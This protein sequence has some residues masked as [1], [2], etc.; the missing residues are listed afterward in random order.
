MSE[1]QCPY[2]GQSESKVVDSRKSNRITREI[3]CIYR[4]RKCVNCNHRFTTYEVREDDM[5]SFI[6]YRKAQEFL[7]KV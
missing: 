4:R 5:K 1:L 3:A 7:A 2:C 6:A